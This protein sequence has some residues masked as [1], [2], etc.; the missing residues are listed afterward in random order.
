MQK[1]NWNFKFNCAKMNTKNIGIMK[2]AELVY[3]TKN[4]KYIMEMERK[5]E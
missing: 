5:K 3:G 1:N 2:K 4:F